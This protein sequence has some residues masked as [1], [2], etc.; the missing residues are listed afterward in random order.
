MKITTALQAACV[1]LRIR[2]VSAQMSTLFTL[3]SSC[4][5]KDVDKILGD[6][7]SLLQAGIDAT[8]DLLRA[9]LFLYGNSRAN[10]KN[11]HNVFGT[12]YYPKTTRTGLNEVD[13]TSVERVQGMLS[14]QSTQPSPNKLQANAPR[15]KV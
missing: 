6:S 3:D 8:D 9:K 14:T 10:M 4:S 7:K 11:M 5:G 2:N 15:Q 12:K 1:A 13:Q